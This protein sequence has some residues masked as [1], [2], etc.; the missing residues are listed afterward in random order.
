MKIT[1]AMISAF[2]SRMEDKHAP[3]RW[4]DRDIRKVI[5]AVLEAANAAPPSPPQ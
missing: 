4:S 1:Q 2:R 3:I 5:R